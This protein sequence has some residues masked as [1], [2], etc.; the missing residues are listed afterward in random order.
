[1]GDFIHSLFAMKN[2]C[3]QQNAKANLYLVND[4]DIWRFGIDKAYEDL[5]ALIINQ[6]YINEFVLLPAGFNE[7][8]VD[9]NSW[10]K[11]VGETHA[12]TG[13]YIK[14]WSDVL[15]D[16]YEF[17]IPTDHRWIYTNEVDSATVGKTVIHR[18]YHRQNNA[19]PWDRIL[20]EIDG[21]ILFVTSNMQDWDS[22]GFK[23]PNIKLHMVSTIGEMTIAINSANRFIGNQSTPFAI[24]CALDVPRLVE[25]DYDP[26]RFYMDETKYSKNISW[27]LNDQQQHIN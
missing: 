17:V 15:S 26:S 14:C 11:V 12:I 2:I 5:R 23:R 9:L 8:F 21:E 18:S 19:F 7:P 22:F 13:S 20:N 10:R 24:A 27:F 25:L 3:A 4:G 6:P 1:M 16:H